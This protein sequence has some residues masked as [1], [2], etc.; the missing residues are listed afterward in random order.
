MSEPV[1]GAVLAERLVALG[2]R[3]TTEA[4]RSNESL[5]RIEAEI[6]RRVRDGSV[7]VNSYVDN[8]RREHEALAA[9]RDRV[10]VALD[11]R[12]HEMNQ[13]RAQMTAREAALVTRDQLDA[14]VEGIRALVDQMRLRI[15]S[16]EQA[17]S[18]LEGRLWML[19]AVLS[20]AMVLINVA[21]AVVLH[22][23]K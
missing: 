14:T 10:E 13:L 8:H 16:G 23:W 19:G 9:E 6:D 7:L 5:T 2:V 11:A 18:N 12:L 17:R 1:D 3:V 20:A 15:E 21:M 4:Q 22:L